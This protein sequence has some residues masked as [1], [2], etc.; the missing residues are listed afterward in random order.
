[1][2]KCVE[3]CN[4]LFLLTTPQFCFLFVYSNRNYQITY[5][6]GYKHNLKSKP[7]SPLNCGCQKTSANSSKFVPVV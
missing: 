5:C 4:T 3:M 7:E 2:Y 1:M 6:L